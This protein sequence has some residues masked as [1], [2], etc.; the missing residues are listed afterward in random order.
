MLYIINASGTYTADNIAEV[1]ITSNSGA[2]ATAVDPLAGQLVIINAD[3]TYTSPVLVPDVIYGEFESAQSFSSSLTADFTTTLENEAVSFQQFH[4]NL[5]A[6]STGGSTAV[7]FFSEQ[8]FTTSLAADFSPAA[9]ATITSLD[10]SQSYSFN[11]IAENLDGTI[12]YSEQQYGFNLQ[13][14][15]SQVKEFYSVQDYSFE[16]QASDQTGI[17][18]D[19]VQEFVFGLSADYMVYQSFDTAQ[20]FSFGLTA[21]YRPESVTSITSSTPPSV[22]AAITGEGIAC[23]VNCRTLEA[24]TY[25]NFPF[26]S[27][28]RQGN[29][30]FA[31][32]S[33]GIYSLSGKTDITTP[34]TATLIGAIS[35]YGNRNLK[36]FPDC[37][38]HLR[39]EGSMELST[40]V[41]EIMKCTY[42][43]NYRDGRQGVHTKR[44]KLAKGVRGRV[45]QLELHNVAG[46]DFDLQEISIDYVVSQR[47]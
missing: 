28:A 43:V 45:M 7:E 26:N 15:S 2:T 30:Y 24:T 40:I 35:D 25:D 9:I 23:S 44:V 33:G 31:T 22:V 36:Y 17:L 13:A 5:S 11:L 39:C 4:F 14:D 46:A 41:D 37:Y 20:S 29:D 21:T 1:L 38:I 34:I 27:L 42:E 16:L 19:S 3:G 47:L 8:S 32:G 10:S 12:S 18:L 6:N